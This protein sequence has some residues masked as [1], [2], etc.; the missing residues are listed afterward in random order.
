MGNLCGNPGSVGRGIEG[1]N[2]FCSISSLDEGVPKL[3]EVIPYSTDHPQT[4][5]HNPLLHL[6]SNIFTPYNPESPI[7]QTRDEDNFKSKDK[8]KPRPLGGI[9]GV[10][11]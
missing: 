10:Y 3:W 9:Y 7:L 2:L 5:D 6:T 11:F 4:C 1:S 8:E